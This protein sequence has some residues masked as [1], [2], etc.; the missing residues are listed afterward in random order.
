MNHEP[1]IAAIAALIGDETRAAMLSVLLGGRAA[2]ASELAERAFVTAQTASEH[3]KKLRTAGL[4]RM[5]KSGRYHYYELAG[6]E[7]AQL[8]E[9]LQLVAPLKEPISE[10]L[11]KAPLSMRHARTCYDHLA[12]QFG[13][14]LTDGLLACGYV[15]EFDNHYSVSK[16]GERWLE[17]YG[18]SLGE[19]QASKRK[20]A[21]PCLDWSERRFH[22]AGSFGLALL[23]MTLARQFVMR[24]EHSRALT[25]TES[26]YRMLENEFGTSIR[27]PFP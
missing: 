6:P 20:F 27:Q 8:L 2:S 21:Y 11:P 24:T 7:V 9:A 25:V 23:N 10:T 12:G 19:V 15:I 22:I 14:A 1:D 3:L 4:I 16:E 17:H 13:I 18:I 26:G 5:R